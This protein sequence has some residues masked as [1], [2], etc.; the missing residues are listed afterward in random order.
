MP[1]ILFYFILFS[2][3]YSEELIRNEEQKQ[4]IRKKKITLAFTDFSILR[5]PEILKAVL[6]IVEKKVR[7]QI[8]STI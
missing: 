1:L 2:V 7:S 3:F 4:E 8:Y 6:K 5:D